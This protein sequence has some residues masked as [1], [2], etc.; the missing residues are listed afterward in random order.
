MLGDQVYDSK[1]AV[2]TATPQSVLFT[3]GEYT[4]HPMST[5]SEDEVA[6]LFT[7]V[8]QRNNP[9]LQ[10]RPVKDLELLGKA[11]FQKCAKLGTGQIAKHEGKVIG[12]Q[13]SWDV[14]EG[15]VW[16]GSDIEMPA[17]L[18]AHAAIGKACFDALPQ[19]GRRTIFCAFSGI[20]PPHSAN[21]FGIMAMCVFCMGRAMGFEDSFQFTIIPNLKGKG[22]FSDSNS[23]DSL[24]WALKFSDVPSERADVLEE[25][26]DLDGSINSQVTAT[27]YTLGN[28]YMKMAA[29]TSRIKNPDDLRH[30]MEVTSANHLKFLRSFDGESSQHL[31]RL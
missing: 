29:V 6:L 18:A 24:N 28:E 5:C 23:D 20:L 11:M 1:L 3:H 15:G 22:V 10:G 13:F 16:N 7:K 4:I 17:S 9:V 2:A 14:A 8:C 27:S 31:A 19:R 21:C 25:L 12:L 30:A 26:K